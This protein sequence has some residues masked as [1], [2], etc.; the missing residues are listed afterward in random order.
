M[1]QAYVPELCCQPIQKPRSLPHD[2]GGEVG[3]SSGGAAP[4]H[5]LDHGHH[6]TGQAD[7]AEA[8][9]AGQRPNALL[10]LWEQEGVLEDHCQAADA[11]VQHPLAHHTATAVASDSSEGNSQRFLIGWV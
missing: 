11:L 4:G 3:V 6:H 1:N 10:M 7:L 9:A 2:V 5:H 8:H